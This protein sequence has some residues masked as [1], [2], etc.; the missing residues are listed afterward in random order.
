MARISNTFLGLVNLLTLVI[1]VSIISLTLFSPFFIPRS[2]CQSFLHLPLLFFGALLFFISLFG[3]FGSCCRSTFLLWVYLFVLFFLI[4]GLVAFTVFAFV[5]TNKGVGAVVSN[6]GY[7]EYRLGDYS[8]WLQEH[9]TQGVTW[10]RIESCLR[11]GL[12]CKSIGGVGG[13]GGGAS[14]FFKKNLSPIQSGCCKPPTSCGYMYQNATYWT[15]PKAG[16]ASSDA[17]CQTW[18]NNQRKLCYGCESCKAGVLQNLKQNWKKLAIL[19]ITLTIVLVIVY[20]IGCC[21]FRNNRAGY[22]RYR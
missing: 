20:S 18:S 14:E 9:V 19:N 10:R 15:V 16:P 11:D 8:H 1:S 12:V 6:R 2:D 3:L 21:A 13:G 17:D 4:L 5:V 7:K 22:Y